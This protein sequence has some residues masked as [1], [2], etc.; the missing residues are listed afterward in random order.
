[1]RNR[2]VARLVSEKYFNGHRRVG[3]VV[4]FR[5]RKLEPRHRV[6]LIG[7][8]P[9]E[10]DG[11]WRLHMRVKEDKTRP[12]DHQSRIESTRL[13]LCFNHVQFSI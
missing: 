8:V 10:Q 3:A 12:E 11:I 7:D 13:C 9:S 4:D 6:K 2:R 1:V 5:K